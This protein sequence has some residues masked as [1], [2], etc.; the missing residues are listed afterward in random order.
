MPRAG[1]TL[2]DKVRLWRGQPLT[3]NA[4]RAGFPVQQQPI[5]RKRSRVAKPLTPERAI[6]VTREVAPQ[7]GAEDTNE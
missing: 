5:S 6:Q 7:P 1:L 3:S 2:Q 4:V